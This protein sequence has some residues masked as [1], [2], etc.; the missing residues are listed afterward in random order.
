MPFL[1][2]LQILKLTG[3]NLVDFPEGSLA[4]RL[5]NLVALDLSQNELRSLPIAIALFTS[6][7]TL[8]VSRN[9]IRLGESDIQ[10]LT[11]LTNLQIVAVL[12][13]GL[14]GQNDLPKDSL[15][16]LQTFS[17]RFPHVKVL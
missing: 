4:T 3:L 15:R 12:V 13:Q 9:N 7:K 5:R 2:Y 17:E 1:P 10:L 8:D 6:L 11:A 16:H 14:F